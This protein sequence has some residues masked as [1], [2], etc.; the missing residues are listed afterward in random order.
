MNFLKKFNESKN[1]HYYPITSSEYHNLHKKSLK[2]MDENIISK[3]T[4]MISGYDIHFGYF[5]INFKLVEIDDR[6][7]NQAII[8]E[9]PDEWFLVRFYGYDLREKC[10]K[11]DQEDGLIEFVKDKMVKKIR[12]IEESVNESKNEH[13]YPITSTEYYKITDDDLSSDNL[14]KLDT[15]L[16][17][18]L[19][20]ILNAYISVQSD[21]LKVST[22]QQKRG[23]KYFHICGLPDEWFLVIYG[24]YMDEKYYKCDQ[25][26]GL[27]KFIEDKMG[28][29]LIS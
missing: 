1:E 3:I 20:N 9:L 19:S 27:I 2:Y 21:Y 7:Y 17:T 26:D 5:G 15:R 13:Y 22:F 8:S 25:E 29:R 16:D 4:N 12:T 18:K 28:E 10:F 11:C 6:L 24:N 23:S 14:L